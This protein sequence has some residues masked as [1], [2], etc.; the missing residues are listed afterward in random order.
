M[1]KVLIFL[2]FIIFS[3]SES[4]SFDF[5]YELK[6]GDGEKYLNNNY[7]EGYEFEFL[8]NFLNINSNYR[9]YHLFLELE[10]SDPPI[11]GYSKTDFDDI[12]SRMY[13]DKQFQDSYFEGRYEATG[14]G[15]SLPDFNKICN[16]Y[17]V[18]YYF[19]ENLQ[20]LNQSIFYI[21]FQKKIFYF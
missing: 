4:P 14:R 21:L 7:D 8:E 13:L 15:Y 5:S 18:K 2:I 3:F 11:L 17:G 10:Y 1:N 9:D 20:E 19:I 6:Y 16:A 12:V